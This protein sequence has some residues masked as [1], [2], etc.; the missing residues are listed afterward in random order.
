MGLE[1]ILTFLIELHFTVTDTCIIRMFAQHML[2]VLHSLPPWRR[3]GRAAASSRP[4]PAH[5]WHWAPAEVALSGWPER[6]EDA[7]CCLSDGS[8]HN[9]LLCGEM[10]FLFWVYPF[11][12]V[13]GLEWLTITSLLGF[14]HIFKCHSFI[15]NMMAEF[16][17]A[18][19]GSG[20]WYYTGWLTVKLPCLPGTL[21]WNKALVSVISDISVFTVMSSKNMLWKRTFS[22]MKLTP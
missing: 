19:S 12:T 6:R 3:T 18:A 14:F 10:T 22:Q 13:K 16:H 7:L 5:C 21:D 4:C 2:Y 1:S 20:S 11:W 15:I 8:L 17:L 9:V